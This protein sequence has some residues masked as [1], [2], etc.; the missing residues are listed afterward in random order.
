INFILVSRQ[1]EGAV[2]A[3][4]TP[5][6]Q[7]QIFRCLRSKNSCCSSFVVAAT[8]VLDDW[9]L[10]SDGFSDLDPARRRLRS[11]YSSILTVRVFS[12]PAVLIY[13]AAAHLLIPPPTIIMD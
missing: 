6:Q 3:A 1:V 4:P 2:S 7:L 10:K 9:I 8:L 5:D 13:A 11:K 12:R